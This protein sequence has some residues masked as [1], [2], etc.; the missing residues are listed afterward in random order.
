MAHTLRRV[1]TVAAL[2][3]CAASACEKR[4]D[5]SRGGT[6]LTF[7]AAAGSTPEQRSAAYRQIAERMTKARLSVVSTPNGDTLTVDVPADADL[8][9]VK[10]LGITRGQLVVRDDG[11]SDGQIV[12][13]RIAGARVERDEKTHKATLIVSL[14]PDDA[15]KVAALSQK[16]VGKKMAVALDGSPL[17]RPVVQTA[18]PGDKLHIPLPAIRDPETAAAEA[19]TLVALLESGALTVAVE[20]AL[21]ERL[22]P[23]KR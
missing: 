19:R 22:A 1:G 6:R 5:L 13:E 7:R 9:R 21:E 4:P 12:I 8:D 20:L 2:L 23:Q 18:I 14:R 3:L 10:N 17:T 15:A 11:S 16:I